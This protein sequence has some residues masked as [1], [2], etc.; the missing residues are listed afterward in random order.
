M[1]GQV[2]GHDPGQEAVMVV[3]ALQAHI[4]DLRTTLSLERA[5]MSRRE[6]TDAETIAF[7]RGQ[8]D[9]LQADQKPPTPD[10]IKRR[11]FWWR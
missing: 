5:Q 8:I 4:E 6:A 2:N 1:P 11:W 3:A 9:R 7:L 10:V